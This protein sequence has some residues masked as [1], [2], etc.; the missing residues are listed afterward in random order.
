MP[1]R[2]RRRRPKREPP[3]RLDAGVP[4]VLVI[5][6][7]ERSWLKIFLLLLVAVVLA[8]AGWR[9]IPDR[10][11]VDPPSPFSVLVSTTAT[12]SQVQVILSP[13][14]DPALGSVDV[15]INVLS[16]RAGSVSVSAQFTGDDISMGDC[17]PNCQTPN[18]TASFSPLGINAARKGK[19]ANLIDFTLVYG[20][21]PIGWYGNGENLDILIPQVQITNR[22]HALISGATAVTS[23]DI[24]GAASYDWG[25]NF[26]PRY[27]SGSY[28]TWTEAI[29]TIRPGQTQQSH[30]P[31]VVSVMN[32]SAQH[33]DNIKLLVTGAVVGTVGAALLGML[34]AFMAP[35]WSRRRL[36]TRGT[37]E[38]PK[39]AKGG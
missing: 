17:S 15:E 5:E 2:I 21:T 23:Y 20:G 27:S 11:P 26:G 10:V 28:I 4:V 12:I 6:K 34:D 29:E 16:S 13:E 22:S 38:G 14:T 3:R 8:V 31:S 36:S 39:A 35:Y 32:P 19:P 1:G 33:E 24:P 30:P 25:P 37:E 7:E 9:I 18:T